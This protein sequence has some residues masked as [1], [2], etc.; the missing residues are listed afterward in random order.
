MSNGYYIREHHSKSGKNKY[1]AQVWLDGKFYTSRTFDQRTLAEAFG[2]KAARDAVS[3]KLQTAARR[4]DFRK[5]Q[6]GL[7]LPLEHWSREYLRGPGLSHS[8]SRR[9]DYQLVGGLLAETPLRAFDGRD[10]AQLIADLRE[11][12]RF[13]RRPR[14]SADAAVT[15]STKPLSDN[16][17]RLRLYALQRIVRFAKTKLPSGA[18]FELPNFEHVFEWKMP[19]AYAVARK[20][21]PTDAEYI[22]L[23]D[24]FGTE[25]DMGHLLRGIDETGCRMSELRLATGAR[26]NLTARDGVVIGGSLTLVEHKTAKKVGP[27]T[28]PLSL[29]AAQVLDR[30]MQQHGQGPL[31]PGMTKDQACDRF[32]AACTR[33]GVKNLQMKDFRRDFVNRNKAQG[34]ALDLAIVTGTTLDKESLSAGE[35]AVVTATGHASPSTT[36][37]YAVPDLDVLGAQFTRTS[38]WPRVAGALGCCAA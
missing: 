21:L 16:T 6:A 12:W 35:R 18:A 5:A 26:V 38:R 19:K 8:K 9:Y 14:S 10:G 36:L 11:R 20:R 13:D 15:S 17:I 29:F 4:R 1:Q 30:R 33:V 2:K 7:D 34:S 37:D 32:D 27:R 3:G 31:F 25:S 24:H 22:A 28:V 23:L